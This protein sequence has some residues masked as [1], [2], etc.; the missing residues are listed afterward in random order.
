[1]YETIYVPVDNSDHSNRA[2][3]TSLSLGKA[4]Q[5]KLVGCHVYAAKMHD[6]RFKQMEF[7]LPEEY[8][9]ENELHR[10]RKIHDSLITM[11]LEMIS[12]C[13]LTDMDKFCR[14]AGLDFE[15]KMMDGKHS[16]E[17]IKDIDQSNYDLVVLGALGIGRTRDAQ[18]GSVCQRISRE[19]ER[20]VWVVKHLP[21]KDEAERDTILI[22]VDGSPESFGAL[23]TG[24]EL[25]RKLNKRIELISVYDPYLHYAVFKGIVEVL[26]EKA[27]KVFRF[28]EQNQLHEE[29]IDTGL[30]EI[31]QSHLNVAETMAKDEG[32]EVG[33]TLL[34]GKA[35][36]KVLDH[37]RKIN[38]YLLI[39]GRVG[40]HTAEEDGGL[41]SNTENL[42]RLA[43]CDIL[44]TTRTETPKI[45]LKAEESIHWTP[46]AEERMT[47]VPE[48][49]KG[50]ARTG[51][52]RLALE[53][54]HSVV[55]S[56]LVTEAMVRFM[57]GASQKATTQLAEALAFEKARREPTSVC[58]QC[59]TVALV[60]NAEKCASCGSIEFDVVTPELI[61]QIANTEGGTEEETTYDG[62][63]LRWTQDA[64]KAL[65]TL[66]D[67][68]QR[69]RAKARI[70]KSARSQRLDTITLEHA[71]RFVEEE[72]GVLYRPAEGDEAMSAADKRK[73]AEAT[74]VEIAEEPSLDE[75]DLKI[76]ARDKKNNPLLSRLAWSEQAIE[77]VL[78][79]PSG[80]MRDRT[81]GRIEELAA[82][83]DLAEIDLALVEEG[84]QMGLQMMQEML[85]AYGGASPEMQA[86]DAEPVAEPVAEVAAPVAE[87]AAP[88]EGVCPV[89]AE[90]AAKE[91]AE[92]AA[93]EADNRG[94]HN[95]RP[96]LNEVG[97][98]TEMSRQ[99]DELSSSDPA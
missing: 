40:V 88:A 98:M 44:L 87:T 70:E 30:A 96:A 29:I 60:P 45:D 54:G 32:V 34:D 76:L 89:A 93:T 51:I 13:Y 83:R 79:V 66:G 71:K 53:K 59:A 37:A 7:T 10:Q 75:G 49:V 12:D 42:L 39:I 64:R 22:G 77:R 72:A 16:T 67:N 55:T 52:L 28:E 15:P 19:V 27:A 80:F 23:M 94:F 24:I 14:A 11:G 86:A 57:P 85:G 38:P 31:Y 91:A 69:R 41:G 97:V 65:R 84:I 3:Q 56:D 61:D 63:K 20:D 9:E 8:L 18:I 81:Q 73:A 78:R 36:Q 1:M 99:R 82:E 25:A 6:Y 21:E 43:P 50:I 62:R 74:E 33:K 47:R 68:Y 4:F 90:R 48:Q 5:S 95:G 46:E 58:R 2:V 35:F 92:K 17:L 26:T